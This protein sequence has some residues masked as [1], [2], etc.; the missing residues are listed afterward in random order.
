MNTTELPINRAI[1]DPELAEVLLHEWVDDEAKKRKAR[2]ISDE[3]WLLTYDS[4]AKLYD[5]GKGLAL[6]GKPSQ[7][8]ISDLVD[9]IERYG[10]QYVKLSGSEDFKSAVASEMEARGL[11]IKHNYSPENMLDYMQKVAYKREELQKEKGNEQ[12]RSN[13]DQRKRS[14]LER[15]SVFSPVLDAKKD[16]IGD[17]SSKIPGR[18]AGDVVE[19]GKAPDFSARPAGD[20]DRSGNADRNLAV[21]PFQKLQKLAENRPSL[22][23]QTDA[24][25]FRQTFLST[26]NK[27]NAQAFAILSNEECEMVTRT[28]DRLDTVE[29][30]ALFGA[31]AQCSRDIRVT[32]ES[33][34]IQKLAQEQGIQ[35]AYLY[36]SQNCNI[37]DYQRP[38]RE[39]K[40]YFARF[41]GVNK[42]PAQ[43]EKELKDAPTSAEITLNSAF[44]ALEDQQAELDE[45]RGKL[46]FFDFSERKRLSQ[47]KSQLESER[48][49]WTEHKAS[50]AFKN[51][52]ALQKR[53]RFYARVGET[54]GAMEDLK[55]ICQ[56]YHSCPQVS[57]ALR[58]KGVPVA[59]ET[60]REIAENRG[61]IPV[62]HDPGL[63]DPEPERAPA[64][65]LEAPE[66]ASPEPEE[67]ESNRPEEVD[68]SEFEEVEQSRGPEPVY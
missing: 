63:K 15:G 7:E 49:R 46:G 24:E 19:S 67:L 36:F 11:Q 31:K 50:K 39:N 18:S 32:A 41:Y 60:M 10:W 57:L 9:S 21:T 53:D 56:P 13:E 66:P 42:T 8:A 1:S 23:I 20:G 29:E 55:D 4:G 12:Q 61:F 45:E 54:T 52:V 38:E 62:L 43:I 26:F 28:L 34:K 44:E 14:G 58:V 48:K 51:S 59:L 33:M 27:L 40:A 5:Y 25:N 68:L 37:A 17:I 16:N 64:V 30:I 47:V 65:K 22:D 2:K 35:A 3:M 6:E